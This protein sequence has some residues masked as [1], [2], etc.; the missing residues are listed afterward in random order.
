MKSQKWEEPDPTEHAG[1][2]KEFAF[3]LIAM[4]SHRMVGNKTV[5][6]QEVRKRGSKEARRPFQSGQGMTLLHY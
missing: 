3:T 2:G 5:T 1:H 4:G 6:G